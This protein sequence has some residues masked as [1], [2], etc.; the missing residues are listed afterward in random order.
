M[1]EHNYIETKQIKRRMRKEE[2]KD[3]WRK[4]IGRKGETGGYV[5][6]GEIV[7]LQYIQCS[8]RGYGCS[9]PRV[10]R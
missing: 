9:L 4:V 5:V 6:T 8:K 1:S 7:I 2:E 3:V 10:P